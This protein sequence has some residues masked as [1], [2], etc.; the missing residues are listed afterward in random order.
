MLY[1]WAFKCG[2]LYPE[3]IH[4]V[5]RMQICLLLTQNS[6]DRKM[7]LVQQALCLITTGQ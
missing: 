4:Y 2:N 3:I 1:K 7:N 5:V 6:L